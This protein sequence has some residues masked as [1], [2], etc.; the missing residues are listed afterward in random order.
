MI[1]PELLPPELT[2]LFTRVFID[3][4]AEARHAFD[5]ADNV[6]EREKHL[7]KIFKMMDVLHNFPGR[8]SKNP[9]VALTEL[10]REF[11]IYENTFSVLPSI[12]SDGTRGRYSGALQKLLDKLDV[13]IARD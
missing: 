2:N 12:D 1:S 10:H 11:L 7:R 9:E 8:F 4:R 6:E 5:A 3:T 13:S